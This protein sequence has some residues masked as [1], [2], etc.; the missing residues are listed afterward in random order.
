MKK[1]E[2]II[3]LLLIFTLWSCSTYRETEREASGTENIKVS[4]SVIVP[5][6]EGAAPIA[7]VAE[8]PSP[9]QVI[10]FNGVGQ[11]V[12]VKTGETVNFIYDGIDPEKTYIIYES[13]D[14]GYNLELSWRNE[15]VLIHFWKLCQ[16]YVVAT[17]SLTNVDIPGNLNLE[18]VIWTPRSDGTWEV[19]IGTVERGCK[20]KAL[21]DLQKMRDKDYEKGVPRK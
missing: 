13:T 12:H 8:L 10:T 17:P 9:G 6:D 16:I 1:F 18:Q 5:K 21:D 15:P 4:K 14:D 7:G 19:R 3:G 11:K 2:I 20:S